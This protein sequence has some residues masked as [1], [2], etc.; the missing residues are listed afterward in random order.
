MDNNSRSEITTVVMP[1]SEHTIQKWNEQ[2][3]EWRDV[4][5]FDSDYADLA[6]NTYEDIRRNAADPENYR[7]ASKVTKYIYYPIR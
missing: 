6:E 4:V 5:T 1:D 2:A 3:Q 7:F